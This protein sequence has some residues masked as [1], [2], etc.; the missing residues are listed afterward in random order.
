MCFPP[1]SLEDG[2]PVSQ[3]VHLQ[4]AVHASTLP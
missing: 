4:L 3:S 2:S 1:L